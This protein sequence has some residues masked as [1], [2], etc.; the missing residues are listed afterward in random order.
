MTIRYP[1]RK[2]VLVWC[3]VLGCLLCIM[4]ISCGKKSPTDSDQKGMWVPRNS[5][6]DNLFIQFLAVHP[7]HS[8][9]IFAGTFGGLYKSTDGAQT[10]VRVD[11]VW[12]NNQ[13]SAIAFDR[14]DPEVIYAGTQGGGILKSEDGGESWEESSVGLEDPTVFSI[15]THP[16]KSD[17][18]FVGIDGGIF[19]SY[20]GADTL[21]KVHW[22]GRAS[23]AIDPQ[24]PQNIYGG[25][26]FNNLHKSTNAGDNWFESNNGL[27]FGSG[28]RR[29][30]WVLID[31]VDPDVIYVGS[32]NIGVYKTTDAGGL[33]LEKNRN[34]SGAKNVRVLGLEFSNTEHLYAATNNG[35]YES[36]DGAENWQSMSAG[37]TNLDIKALAVDSLRPR[38]LYA[39]TWGGGV[40]IWQE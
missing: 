18:L 12:A 32:N 16:H 21:T 37:L 26:K 14:L 6:L 25:G 11:S 15:A 8:S 27:V 34:L 20:D 30:Q 10:W 38:M 1:G 36:T 7:A 31:P 2:T 23:L 28:D 22:Y 39:G 9:I 3:L 33:W 17:T 35:V 13:V 19:R 24:N 5:G 29:I 40:F 4:A